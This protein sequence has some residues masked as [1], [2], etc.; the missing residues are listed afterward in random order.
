MNRLHAILG[1][2]AG[3]VSVATALAQQPLPP[4]PLP[5]PP[6]PPPRVEA[7]REVIVNWTLGDQAWKF[8]EILTAYEPV[9]G[10]LEARP[11]RG[12]LAVWKLRLLRDFE[13]GA[14]TLHTE[15][16]G[17]PFKIVLLDAERT[18]IDADSPA[19]ITPVSGRM[20]DTIELY[21]ALPESQLLKDVKMIRVEK[22][23]DVGF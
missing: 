18:V 11:G 3:L 6:E 20:D 22:R 12:M 17:S 19:Q 14:A 13:S 5:Q 7:K 15:T 2:L 8:N 9:K 1:T 21:V 4:P 23:T 16:R 10:Y